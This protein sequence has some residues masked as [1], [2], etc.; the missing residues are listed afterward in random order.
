MKLKEELQTYGID[1]SDD[2]ADKLMKHLELVLD[3]TNRVQ[4]TTI[5]D[6]EIGIRLHICDSLTCLEEVEAAPEGPVVDMG[7]GGGYPGIPL[8]IVTG[9]DVTLLDS[10]KKKCAVLDGFIHELNLTN[11]STAPVRAEELA[12]E[13]PQGYA[14]ATA[15]ALSSLPSLVELASPLL[16]KGGILIA[17]KG[18]ITDEELSR[19][20]KAAKLV[21]MSRVSLR[22]FILSG[23]DEKRA[24]V[25]YKKVSD[26]KRKLPRRS[27]MAQRQPL[28]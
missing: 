2:E 20:D 16:T 13:K 19:G 18:N 22:R 4:L 3:A 26:S 24:I 14:V 1:V 7:T 21:G 11:V 28:A 9:R 25:V 5:K 8:S 15:R 10:V 17:Q 27:G 12:I 6:L 23:S